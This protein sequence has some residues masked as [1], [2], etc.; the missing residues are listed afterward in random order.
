MKHII[1]LPIFILF[2]DCGST[3]DRINLHNSNSTEQVI[4]ANKGGESSGKCYSRM[5]LGNKKV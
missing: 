2:I 4:V 1:E 5:M 3:N